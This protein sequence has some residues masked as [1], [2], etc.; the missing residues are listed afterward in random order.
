MGEQVSSLIHRANMLNPQV[1]HVD[2][3]G[4]AN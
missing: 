2:Y 3:T 4:Q 1:K